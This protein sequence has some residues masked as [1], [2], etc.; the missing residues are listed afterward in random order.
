MDQR[1]EEQRVLLATD[2]PA[3]HLWTGVTGICY[4]RK[5]KSSP[6]KVVRAETWDLLRKELE[7][8]Q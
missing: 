7:A 3:W 5:P 1:R 8:A 2:Y 4:A 6:P